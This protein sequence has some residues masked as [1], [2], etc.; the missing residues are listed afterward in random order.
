MTESAQ[1]PELHNKIQDYVNHRSACTS[2]QYIFSS[3]ALTLIFD[4]GQTLLFHMDESF[5]S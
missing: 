1:G 5:V 3:E 2:K 4:A